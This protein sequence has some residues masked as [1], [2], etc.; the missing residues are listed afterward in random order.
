MNE[1]GVEGIGRTQGFEL[2][3]QNAEIFGQTFPFGN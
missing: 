2:F 3:Q 1:Q